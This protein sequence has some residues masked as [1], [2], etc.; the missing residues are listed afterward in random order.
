MAITD[1]LLSIF[2]GAFRRKATPS[3]DPS[4]SFLARKASAAAALL[5]N[6]GV[7]QP[8]WTPRRF[9]R[10]AD[11]AY[12]WNA[13]AHSCVKRI[14]TAVAG[15]SWLL[16]DD[17]NGDEIEKHP[18]LQLL[19]RPNPTMTGLELIEAFVAFNQ[20]AGISYIE[21]V[22]PSSGPPR[23]LWVL[24]PDRIH[25]LEG[26]TGVPAGYRYETAKGRRDWPVDPI[27]GDSDIIAFKQ[28]HPLH[29]WYGLSPVE[30]AAASIDVSNGARAYNQKILANG[31]SVPGI[32]VFKSPLD[33]EQIEA[34]E[35]A[36]NSRWRDPESMGG[37]RILGGDWS[38]IQTG[39]SARD[40]Q[41]FELTQQSGR[42]ICAAFGVPH[43]LVIPGESTYANREQ[44][45]L[46]LYEATVLPI[47]RKIR[48]LLN[49]TLCRRF[50]AV[51][52][53]FDEDDI[54]A[55]EPRRQGRREGV[56]ALW[57]AGLITKNE[58]RTSLQFD[59]IGA[60]GDRFAEVSFMPSG[61]A[62]GRQA[63]PPEKPGTPAGGQADQ[64]G[65]DQAAKEVGE[66][67][68]VPFD[69]KAGGD[70]DDE[71]PQVP[72]PGGYL[73]EIVDQLPD[74]ELTDE[75]LPIIRNAMVR[76]GEEAVRGARV[77]FAFDVLDPKV[78]EYLET[79]GATRIKQLIGTT[80]RAALARSLTDGVQ[81]GESTDKLRQRVRDVFKVASESRAQMIAET[82]IGNASGFAAEA[83]MVQAGT[84]YKVWLATMDSHTRDTHRAMNGQIREV[85]ELFESPSGARGKG[86]GQFGVAAED[87]YCRCASIAYE[88]EEEEGQAVPQQVLDRRRKEVGDR[89]RE[90]DEIRRAFE[91]SA[92]EAVQRG[93]DRQRRSIENAMF[94]ASLRPRK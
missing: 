56:I 71:P 70:E 79:Y 43:I 33:D 23:E 75:L 18:I 41:F 46:E 45:Y 85:G 59:E 32:M 81:L 9:D 44:A 1:R 47:M 89:W 19:K 69:T 93:L 88:P 13:I 30:P 50:G 91:V 51:R 68:V 55:L 57:T 27:T 31:A 92:F 94:W 5:V 42:E 21:Q 72:E 77:D 65:A 60:E 20:L 38:Y 48:D 66:A 11:E 12:V 25:I 35:S 7:G 90:I 2:T 76:V 34:A 22:S 63:K 26:A 86:P 10:L 4:A 82:E 73:N 14:A 8:V 64:G 53:D 58:A 16:Y 40:M 83:A 52:L 84:R 62:S 74:G 39:A 6:A 49:A 3:P 54:P 28:F 24:R 80:T 87:I 29:D 36:L 61:N 15:A 37:Y 67:A 17:G 78:V